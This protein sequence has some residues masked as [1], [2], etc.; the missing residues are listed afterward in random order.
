MGS[1]TKYSPRERANTRR[2]ISKRIFLKIRIFLDKF[3]TRVF[4]QKKS[5]ETQTF[6]LVEEKA[7]RVDETN[8]VFVSL[9]EEAAGVVA[10]DGDVE[11][12]PEA[13]AENELDPKNMKVA[14]LR[15]ELEARN[16]PSKGE[17]FKSFHLVSANFQFL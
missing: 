7:Q 14:E 8:V 12:E 17:L 2:K 1:T 11:M 16:L 4:P 10:E 6:C 9:Q 3:S 5:R 13:G 15:T